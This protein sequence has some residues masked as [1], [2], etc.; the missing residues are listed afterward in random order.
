MQG[1]KA[2]FHTALRKHTRNNFFVK[3]I[4]IYIT[5]YDIFL[6]SMFTLLMALT[7]FQIN[8]GVQNFETLKIMHLTSNLDLEI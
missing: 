5:N 4:Y 7:I 6:N 8:S 3:L 2:N 1:F